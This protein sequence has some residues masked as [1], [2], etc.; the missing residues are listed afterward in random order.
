MPFRKL[1]GPGIY[2][3]KVYDAKKRFIPRFF[4]SG[5]HLALIFSFVLFVVV[6]AVVVSCLLLKPNKAHELLQ[7]KAERT[8]R[9]EASNAG[10]GTKWP[11]A[12]DPVSVLR[13]RTNGTLLLNV[14]L[15]IEQ[16]R[17]DI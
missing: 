2:D 15:Y 7:S 6:V 1:V 4:S 12:P 13:G 3:H 10:F 17:N 5:F 11:P 8:K 16:S 9:G 14:E